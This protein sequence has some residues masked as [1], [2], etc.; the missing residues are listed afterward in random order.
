MKVGE[1][2][3]RDEVAHKKRYDDRQQHGRHSR[4]DPKRRNVGKR[5]NDWSV[6]RRGIAMV[7]GIEVV[8]EPF[9]DDGDQAKLQVG[10]PAEGPEEEL[11]GALN[12]KRNSI[13]GR[14]SA[15]RLPFRGRHSV[16][17]KYAISRCEVPEPAAE[18]APTDRTELLSSA[19]N[20]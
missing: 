16:P 15:H 20:P 7:R 5:V 8:S 19:S 1:P 2:Q 14:D 18:F 3:P 4:G 10:S 9:C 11:P 17:R 12:S 6:S 13:G